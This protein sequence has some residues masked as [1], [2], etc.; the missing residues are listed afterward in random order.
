MSGVDELS[1]VMAD[2]AAGSCRTVSCLRLA[3][4]GDVGLTWGVG[5]LVEG[6]AGLSTDNAAAV[7]LPSSLE[8][9]HRPQTLDIKYT[10]MITTML[11]TK[12][13]HSLIKL[14]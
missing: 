12:N 8:L 14:S 7:P 9:V 2:A 11:I 3:A 10:I 1:A 13:A 5:C 4:T 6:T